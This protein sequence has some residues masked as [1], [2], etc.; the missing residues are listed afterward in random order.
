VL[1]AR[2]QSRMRHVNVNSPVHSSGISVP[3]VIPSI[4]RDKSNPSIPVAVNILRI[5]AI[6]SR[7]V[8]A[9]STQIRPCLLPLEFVGYR[10]ALLAA[11]LAS[12]G[13]IR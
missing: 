11:S 6:V 1:S 2:P 3:D 12:G 4:Y 8:I 7:E 5:V 9:G 13:G 10:G